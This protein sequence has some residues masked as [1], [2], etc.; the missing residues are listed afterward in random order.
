MLFRS[1]G[2]SPQ[3]QVEYS[4]VSEGCTIGQSAVSMSTLLKGAHV[5]DNARLVASLVGQGA[6][7]GDGCQ[8]SGVVVDHE[9]VVPNGTV[10]NGGSWP[11]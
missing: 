9:A 8:L 10:Q 11:S 1:V 4:M 7:I 3:A 6:R 5:G 2:V